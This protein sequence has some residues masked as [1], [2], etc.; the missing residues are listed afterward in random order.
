MMLLKRLLELLFP[1]KC[2]LCRKVLRGAQ[3]DLCHECRA[4]APVFTAR[5]EK[6]R[7][8]SGF[9]AVWFYEDLVRGSLLRYKFY[10]ARS[11]CEPYG[12]LLAMRI[13]QA[14]ERSA[15][16]ITWVPVGP[17]RRRKRGYDQVELIAEQVSLELGIPAVKLLDKPRDNPPQSGIPNAEARR[18]NVL[19]MYR[20]V[21]PEWIRDKRVLLLDDIVTTGATV[22]ECARV[23]LSAGAKQIDCAAVAAGRN[24]KQ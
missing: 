3:T 11:Y 14:F 6:L 5:Q 12:R 22:S 23:L 21:H 9:T 20:A 17:K 16:V 24:Q 15:D 1:P 19:G 13:H 2:V 18:A 10:H 8:I 4:T 7:Y